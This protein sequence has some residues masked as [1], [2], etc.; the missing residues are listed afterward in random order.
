[1]DK[2]Y[3]T[4]AE[5]GEGELVEKKSRF[6]SFA[7]G[8]T[9]EEEAVAFISEI[10]KKYPDARH[11]VY[12]YRVTSNPPYAARYSD[13]GEPQGTGGIPVLDVLQKRD[14]GDAALAV[15]RYFGGILLGAPGLVRAYSSAASLAVQNAGV[16]KMTPLIPLC[17]RV[18]Y[19]I[20]GKIEAAAAQMGLMCDP[21]E[22]AEDVRCVFYVEAEKLDTVKS[23]FSDIS[24]GKASFTQKDAEF[25]PV[26]C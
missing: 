26:R 2:P 25:F 14:I 6:L 5:C 15:V 8:V 18:G 13:D 21:P 17:V 22:Y 7:R 19:P 4:L 11:V 1:M 23:S 20:W 10:R 12:A 9:S 3:I 16:V 24:S